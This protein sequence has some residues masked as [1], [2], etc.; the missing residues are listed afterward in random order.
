MLKGI[1]PNKSQL[2]KK[3]I[4]LAI[5]IPEG[6]IML[7]IAVFLDVAGFFLF[8]LSLF[9]VGIPLSWLVTMAGAITISPWL[10]TRSFFKGAIDKATENISEKVTNIGKGPEQE[11]SQES[12]SPVIETGKKVV[13]TGAKGVLS[14]IRF[15]IAFIIEM[16][17]FLNNFFP[18]WTFLVVFEL[19]Q[20]EI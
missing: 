3:A 10:A 12:S 14:L 5:T 13:K 7:T 1:I 4:M 17:P 6:I 2:T 18:A 19:V 15:V 16:V 20:G 8:I 11:K 9:G